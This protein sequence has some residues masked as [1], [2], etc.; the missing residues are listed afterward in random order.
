MESSRGV[1]SLERTPLN[2]FLFYAV[3]NSDFHILQG[4]QGRSPCLVSAP[5]QAPVTELSL[6]TVDFALKEAVN[7]TS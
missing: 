6:R 4:Y 3:L 1:R 2:A 5:D 7:S